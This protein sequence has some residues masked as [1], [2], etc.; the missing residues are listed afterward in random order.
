MPV[1]FALSGPDLGRSFEVVEGSLIGRV[2]ECDVILRDASVSRRHARLEQR[3]ESWALVDLGSSNG[4]TSVGRRAKELELEDGALFEL[5]KV[6]M[7]FR[8][9]A[10][11]AGTASLTG[12]SR[13]PSRPEPTAGSEL[14][15][16]SGLDD[17]PEGG[18][19]AEIV[20]EDE[21][22]LDAP[23]KPGSAA[24]AP[25]SPPPSSP[26]RATPPRMGG[27]PPQAV[28]SSGGVEVRDAGR[29]ILQ[30]SKTPARRGFF[31][32]DLAQYPLWVRLLAGILVAAVF[33]SLFFVAY[34]ATGAMKERAVGEAELEAGF[35]E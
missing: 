21:E 31:Q 10:D 29:P 13:Q 11:E 1:L 2:E 16:D 27:D 3:G 6:E 9:E 15:F 20:L 8:M 19:S 23:P 25:S 4:I 34:R 32:A 26:P 17:E 24:Q 18:T 35:E 22:L 14:L 12:R 28:P 5:G 33:V 7:R 30:Y